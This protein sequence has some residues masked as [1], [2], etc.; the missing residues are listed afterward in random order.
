MA[1]GPACT[2]TAHRPGT[3]KKGFRRGGWG[4]LIVLS[5][6]TGLKIHADAVVGAVGVG[7]RWRVDGDVAD[8]TH[9]GDG[10]SD[11]VLRVAVVDHGTA[12][13]I[14]RVVVA[15]V[16]DTAP[17]GRAR[18]DAHRRHLADALKTSSCSRLSADGQL[19]T[20]ELSMAALLLG[21]L[22]D[23]A[24]SGHRLAH[25]YHKPQW[26]VTA[27]ESNAGAA[28]LERRRGPSTVSLT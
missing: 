3:E 9:A 10:G 18:P 15:G 11:L 14:G 2:A 17:G 7:A 20:S 22:C 4:K 26:L 16:A 24:L 13:R 19:I 12:L 25:S 6:L 28:E 21:H 1:Q 27:C 5:A 8:G 23:N